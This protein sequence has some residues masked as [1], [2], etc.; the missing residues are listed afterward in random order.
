MD[1]VG[2]S[3][4]LQ[5]TGQHILSLGKQRRFVWNLQSQNIKTIIYC[6]PGNFHQQLFMQPCMGKENGPCSRGAT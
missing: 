4:M 2:D 1:N 6:K 5:R 3:G